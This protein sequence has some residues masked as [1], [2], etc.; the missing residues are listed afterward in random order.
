[1]KRLFLI[2]AL[3]MPFMLAAQSTGNSFFDRY[4]GQEGFTSITITPKMFELLAAMSLETGDPETQAIMDMVQQ[5]EG[6]TIL[7]YEGEGE[8]KPGGLFKEA[9]ASIKSGLFEELMTV[10]GEDEKIRFM[11]QD[12]KPGYV[13]ELLMIVDDGNEFVFLSLKGNIELAQVAKLAKM[14]D[15]MGLDGLEKLGEIER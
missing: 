3:S 13:K 8:A 2:L 12:G 9:N 10:N 5:V 7:V 15:G 4:S 14:A 1:M 11:V 6:L